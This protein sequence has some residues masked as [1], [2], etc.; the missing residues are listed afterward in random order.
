MKFKVFRTKAFEKEFN[1]LP[2]LEQKETEKFEGELS[3][4]PFLGRPLSYIFFRE[5]RLNGRRVYYLVYE[6]YV[7]VLMV[8]VS[9]KKTQQETINKIKNKLKEYQEVI[10][11]TLKKL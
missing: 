6:D 4:N 7:V 5:K 9:D 2:K 11:E 1:K 10:K 8:A 3:S